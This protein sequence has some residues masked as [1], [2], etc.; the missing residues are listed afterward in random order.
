MS[1]ICF[2][3][4]YLV[5]PA[6]FDLS[7]DMYCW[8]W[9][10]EAPTAK[11]SVSYWVRSR[12]Y[13]LS[14]KGRRNSRIKHVLQDMIGSLAVTYKMSEKDDVRGGEC[15][16][17]LS[18]RDRR[19]RRRGVICVVLYFQASTSIYGDG[20]WWFHCATRKYPKQ[21]CWL[22]DM[23]SLPLLESIGAKME[24]PN[25][26]EEVQHRA[27]K[28]SR[29]VNVGQQKW[30]FHLYSFPLERPRKFLLIHRFQLATLWN[31][32]RDHWSPSFYKYFALFIYPIYRPS[33]ASLYKTL[34]SFSFPSP[35]LFQ[36]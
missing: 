19:R 35:F 1:E 11:R 17:L 36:E 7:T 4:N 22:S 9:S 33:S 21:R 2:L 28:S 5:I 23:S 25:N 12:C 31:Q 8:G 20:K 29:N 18:R 14:L 26:S 34:L 27:K 16:L 13:T 6:I 24:S 32:Q 15:Y 3:K 30:G 10:R